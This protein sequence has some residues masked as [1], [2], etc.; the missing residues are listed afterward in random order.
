MKIFLFKSLKILLALLALLTLL[1]ML[2]MAPACYKRWVR[3]PKLEKARSTLWQS[4]RQPPQKIELTDYKGVLHS[5]SYWSHDS[6]GTL[7]EILPAA[8]EAGLQ[9]IFFSDHKRSALDTFPRAY[10]G[11]YEG[12]LMESGTESGG[13]MV[14]PLRP[15]VLNWQLPADS[16]MKSVVSQ[17][18]MLLYVHSEEAHAWDN[19]Y[20]QGMEIYNIHTDLKDETHLFP[21]LLNALINGGPYRHWVY[22]ELYDPQPA[23][24]A[25][26]DSLNQHR[27]IIGMAAVDA[28]DNQSLRARYVPGGQVEW[29]G[30]NA[31]T[32]ALKQPGWLEAW[33]LDPAGS[34]KWAFRLGLDTY[35][36]SFQFVNT[37]IFSDSLSAAKL[38]QHL[39]KGHAYIA[40]ESLAEASGFQFF[41]EKAGGQLTGIMGDSVKG[42]EVQQIRAFSPFPVRFQLMRDGELV[43][44]QGPSYTYSF[45]PRGH[46]GNYRMVAAL[47]LGDQW[48]EWVLTNPMYV[49]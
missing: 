11:L 44:R 46:K 12:V 49:Y 22:R 4:Y 40:F 9:Y 29:V 35:F 26:W 1:G 23:I 34:E 45:D 33:L 25:L 32:L 13:M 37:H 2:L 38:K 39:L 17:G 10:Q 31:K 28:H 43:D 18:G 27:R 5:H 6:R 42:E 16:L 41:A 3:Y 19:P 21:F 47:R 48:V 14:T 20:Y 24:W 15:T 36:H 30:P 7:D 8:K